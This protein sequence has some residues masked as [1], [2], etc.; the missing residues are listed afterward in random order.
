MNMKIKLFALL[1]LFK[2]VDLN[3]LNKVSEK[4]ACRKGASG[5]TKSAADTGPR[6]DCVVVQEFT[7][8]AH[9][10]SRINI[11]TIR[12]AGLI[13]TG[14]AHARGLILKTE[15]EDGELM[16]YTTVTTK[17]SILRARRPPTKTEYFYYPYGIKPEPK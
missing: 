12:N 13:S 10:E 17:P 2:S 15:F 3:S 7:Y 5:D 16:S 4:R 14:E 6:S 9:P 8:L 11:K 1:L